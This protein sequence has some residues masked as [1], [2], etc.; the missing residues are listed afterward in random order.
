VFLRVM[1][2]HVNVLSVGSTPL[3]FHSGIGS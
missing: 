3:C 1:S 2:K